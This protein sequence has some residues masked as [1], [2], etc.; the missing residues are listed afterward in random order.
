MCTLVYYCIHCCTSLYTY[1][2]VVVSGSNQPFEKSYGLKILPVAGDGHC[3]FHTLASLDKRRSYMEWR[4][5]LCD[6]VVQL[7]VICCVL[8]VHCVWVSVMWLL[9]GLGVDMHKFCHTIVL[10]SLCK[11]VEKNAYSNG[12]G[13]WYLDRANDSLQHVIQARESPHNT[14]YTSFHALLQA[15]RTSEWGYSDFIQVFCNSMQV[16]LAY[17][18]TLVYSC[19][20]LCSIHVLLCVE[21]LDM[22]SYVLMVLNLN[23]GWN[24]WLD[25]WWFH[26]IYAAIKQVWYT[27]YVFLHQWARAWCVLMCA[28]VCWCVLMCADVC[29]CVLMCVDCVLWYTDVYCMVPGNPIHFNPMT[30]I[31]QPTTLLTAMMQHRREQWV[32]GQASFE[33]LFERP[34]GQVHCCDCVLVYY[35]YYVYYVFCVLLCSL[36]YWYAPPSVQLESIGTSSGSSSHKSKVSWKSGWTKELAG[37]EGSQSKQQGGRR[38]STRSKSKKITGMLCC[39]LLCTV[40][41]C[42]VLLCVVVYCTVV[43]CCVLLCAVVFYVPCALVCTLVYWCVLYT[44]GEKDRWRQDIVSEAKQLYETPRFPRQTQPTA[45]AK[46]QAL[47]RPFHLMDH[48]DS[49]KNVTVH[50]GGHHFHTMIISCILLCS[51]VFH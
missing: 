5:Y 41:C 39:V 1:V 12:A 51:C 4:S 32:R 24:V 28:D 25:A 22:H 16:T 35:L 42:C 46:T 11:Q 40:V 27:T 45:K 33:T 6:E 19:G 20:P 3:L 49:N 9:L 34:D 36:V 7:V 44:T 47:K 31:Q 48:H 29:W 10:D 30:L 14:L 37:E 26:D 2:Y 13:K 18:C 23:A 43:C 50:Y 21:W 15:M 38:S 17:P 8:C